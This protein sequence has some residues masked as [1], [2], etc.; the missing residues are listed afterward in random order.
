MTNIHKL[1]IIA[2]LLLIFVA[3]TA[4]GDFYAASSYAIPS[5][6]P[7]PPPD[8]P[9]QPN[10]YY[11]QVY[12]AYD[13]SRTRPL[14]IGTLSYEVDTDF[15][16]QFE[17]IHT[18][19]FIQVDIEPRTIIIWS[20]EPLREI[21]FVSLHHNAVCCAYVYEVLLTVNNFQP[22]DALVLTVVFEHYLLPR[23][24]ILFTDNTGVRHHMF[25]I[26][27][28]AD[29]PAFILSPTN[30]MMD[31]FTDWLNLN[32]I[33]IPSTFTY[34]I[35][36]LHGSLLIKSNCRAF[37]KERERYNVHIWVGYIMAESIEWVVENSLHVTEFIFDDGHWGYRLE[38]ERG[39][40][41]WIRHDWTGMT[42]RYGSNRFV[43]E[44]HED[45]ISAIA[46]TLQPR[47]TLCFK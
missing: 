38:S 41:S 3:F 26:E 7:T 47:C 5:Q 19:S 8:I 42:F 28:M 35:V 15:L 16:S 31:R 45:F 34:E 36:G 20:D 10:S 9:P 29:G 1:T 25:I 6:A 40:V 24:G 23:A 17:N 33:R 30:H 22:T 43:F 14:N 46:R 4:C 11:E 21:S 44:I 13:A 18:Y 12:A 37:L 32:R 27:S 2:W 39:Y